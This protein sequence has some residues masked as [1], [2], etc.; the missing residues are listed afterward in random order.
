MKYY[1]NTELAKL[2]NISEKSVRNWIEGTQTG[3]LELELFE[4][5]G[6]QYIAN[7]SRNTL[8]I[9]ELVK[10]G[11]KYRNTRGFKT[12]SPTQKFNELYSTKQIL[13]IIANIDVHHEIPYQYNYFD[14]GAQ[15]WN[16][17]TQRL[18]EEKVPSTLTSTI[19]QL[20]VNAPYLETLLE[21]HDFVN[22]IDIGV[23]NCLPV[24]D[25]LSTLAQQGR[26]KRY[27]AVDV[28]QDML[29]I[30]E[31]NIKD[32]FGDSV[33]F[34]GYVRDMSYERFDDLLTNESFDSDTNNTANIIT[35]FGGT[36]QNLREPGRALRT[37]NDSMGKHDLLIT[38]TKLDSEKSRRYFDFA[39]SANT[40][41]PFAGFRGKSMLD[42]LN[43]E[44]SFYSLEQFFDGQKMM[45]LAR[46]TLDVALSIEFKLKGG[47]RTVDL[48]K[49]DK[50]H[51]W[52]AQ[53]L[54]TLQLVQLYDKNDFDLVFTSLSKDR[55]YLLAI[56]K[57]KTNL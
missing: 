21:D 19:E 2:Y 12:I 56:F 7:T 14:G 48:N 20:T 52:R 46:V 40:K 4:S 30:A 43:I 33:H 26:L 45:R 32:W 53:H 11:K 29:K 42:L 54:N 47:K 13:D 36:I 39:S 37:I 44:P 16:D 23:G 57:V 6:K 18:L 50:I 31:K 9:E 27:I 15:H 51:L 24:R 25:F 55:E 8:A 41:A 17:Y 5:N 28:S 49:G 3:R 34:E 10:K 1:K 22:V 38:D 35:L